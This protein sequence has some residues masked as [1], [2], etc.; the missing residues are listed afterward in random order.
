MKR[1]NCVEKKGIFHFWVEIDL[2]FACKTRASFDI[3]AFFPHSCLRFQVMLQPRRN[4]ALSQQTSQEPIEVDLSTQ[5][6]SRTTS[7]L[8][9][10]LF[11]FFLA[12]FGFV[13]GG[14]FVSGLS[15]EFLQCCSIPIHSQCIT[16]MVHESSTQFVTCTT[17]NTQSPSSVDF[18]HFQHLCCVHHVEALAGECMIRSALLNQ[19]HLPSVSFAQRVQYEWLA[20]SVHS[21]GDRCLLCTGLRPPSGLT[22]SQR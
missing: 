17:C 18:L 22:L 20:R 14:H 13:C 12:F 8:F 7:F 4:T 15:C 5:T 11:L 16:E 1:N 2:W 10:M 19:R 6:V 9:L 21:F 3:F